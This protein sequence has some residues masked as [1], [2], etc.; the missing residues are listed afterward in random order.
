MTAPPYVVVDDGPAADRQRLA[1][2]ERLHAA[3][4]RVLDGLETRPSLTRI[5][6]CGTVTTPRDAANALLAA[7]DGCGLLLVVTADADAET[8]DRLVD[9][10]R[11]LGPVEHVDSST[12]VSA[13]GDGP[14]SEEGRAILAL[15]AEGFTLGEAATQ[16]ALSRRT[17]DRRLS[18][19]RAALGVSRTTEAIAIAAR[20]GLLRR[21]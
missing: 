11:R 1:A 16:L 17:A 10:L 8:R 13:I 5:V 9:D 2:E 20:R 14:L 18:E 12:G 6:L 3:G 19:A 15:L 7:L 21:R 4:W